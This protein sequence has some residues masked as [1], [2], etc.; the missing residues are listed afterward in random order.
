MKIDGIYKGEKIV[1]PQEYYLRINAQT[2]ERTLVDIDTPPVT[3][4]QFIKGIVKG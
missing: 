4:R 2:G 3:L 1:Q